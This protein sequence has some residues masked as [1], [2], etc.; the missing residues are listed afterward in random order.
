MP[1]AGVRLVGN[2][3]T[4]KRIVLRLLLELLIDMLNDAEPDLVYVREL[5]ATALDEVK[6]P[7]A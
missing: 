2:D 7:T 6:E 5:A 1:Q 3:A 4:R